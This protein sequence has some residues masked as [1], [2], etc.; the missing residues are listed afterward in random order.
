MF[1][2]LEILQFA[3]ENGMID[4]S[5]I[6]EKMLMNERKKYLEKHP[7]KI[8]EG[9]D[10]KWYT[11]LPCEEN[12]RKLKRLA[13]KKAI[14]DSIVSYYKE[15][16][17]DPTV[18][19]IF[20]EWIDNKLNYNEIKKQT[21]D[22]YKVDFERYFTN[23]KFVKDFH[24]RKIKS[25][26]EDDLECFIKTSIAKMEL[27][28]KAYSGMRILIIGIFKQA[29]K[30]TGI[31]ISS[32]MK[33]LDL[34][35]RAF[36]KRIVRKENEVYQEAEAEKLTM[37][38]KTQTDDMR[39]LGLLLLF[40][41]GLRVGELCGLK[42]SDIGEKFIHVQ[43]TEIKYKNDKGKWESTIQNFTKSEAGDRCIIINKNAMETLNKVLEI[44]GDGEYL[45]CEDGK[46]IRSNGF[47]RKLMRCCQQL[48]IEYKSNHK[49]RKTYG[50]MLIDG[51]VDDSIV[52]E[53]MGHTDISTTRKYYYFSNKS[54]EKKREQIIKA[55]CY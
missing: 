1:S 19:M 7:Y 54:E 40:Q 15:L 35:Q 43:R 23:N 4:E 25:I 22:R 34:S 50:T 24:K 5:T 38:L 10:G 49:I 32:F 27:T 17:T 30:Y 53:Q 44:R 16:E 41:T 9:K 33:D 6:Q 52:A 21:Y 47:R 39:C 37:Y 12:G 20:N 28:Q 36:R 2:N 13:N 45:F 46:R 11:Y 42:V 29:K 48:E 18:E 8:W 55:M 31:S 3:I 14:E 51:G 26:T